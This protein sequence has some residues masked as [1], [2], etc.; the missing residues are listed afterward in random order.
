MAT[1][2]ANVF[3]RET[4]VAASLQG[5][6]QFAAAEDFVVGA[7]IIQLCAAGRLS[8]AVMADLGGRSLLMKP[9]RSWV[10]IVGL[11]CL[12]TAVHAG[13]AEGESGKA[14]TGQLQEVVVTAQF[15]SEKLQETPIA[16][17]AVDAAAM[18]A[19]G[20]TDLADAANH[21]PSVFIA[22]SAYGFGQSA[23]VTIRGI[24]QADPHIALEPGVGVYIDDVYYGMLSGS[25]FELLD[26]DRVE[27]LRGPQG[28]LQG[29]N[30]I[31]GSVK[32][33]STRPGPE[34]N[35]FIEAGYGSFNHFMARAASNITLIPDTLFARVSAGT[36]HED[37][38]LTELDYTC[39]TGKALDL[40]PGLSGSNRHGTS[41]CDIGTEGGKSVVSARASLR[42]IASEQVEDTFIADVTNDNSENPAVKLLSQSPSWAG[43]A[44]FI[45]C[46]TCYTNYETNLGRPFPGSNV[47][48]LPRTSP[49][50]EWGISNTLDVTL[51]ASIRLKSITGYRQEHTVFTQQGEA[52]PADVVDQIWSMQTRQFTE[53][54][55]LLGTIG[56]IVD[57]TV[58]GFFYDARGFSSGR[59][60]IPGGFALGG[61]G[62]GLDF[63]L[64][65]P[66]RTRSTSGFAHFVVHATDR[67]DVTLAGR[68]THDIKN[69]T[70]NR[71][72][73]DG[74]PY[75]LLSSLEDVTGRFSGNR[76]DYRAAIDYRWTDNLLT[77]A[78]VSTGFKG[79]GVNPRPY[80][81]SQVVNFNPETLLTY[82][83]GLKS[84]FL[85]HRARV[86][87]AAYSSKYKDI[88]L[89]L[90]RCDN[91]SPF[92]GAPCAATENVGDANVKGV[93]LETELRPTRRW[94]FDASVGY[95]DF[96]YT[97]T[98]PFSG[99]TIGMQNIYAPKLTASAGTQYTIELPNG[100]SL[101]P[102]VDYSYRSEIWTLPVNDP[103]NRIGG[104]GLANARLTWQDSSQVWEAAL[105]ITNLTNKFYYISENPNLGAPYFANIGTPGR[106]REYFF[107]VK[108]SF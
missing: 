13:A 79:G 23:S 1:V 89:Q 39:A 60:Q 12:G 96:R 99:V 73:L 16:I 19:R 81:A 40:G 11:G 97:R 84:E 95:M 29:K 35:A 105:A 14:D 7:S 18:A 48:S 27:V 51:P 90:L 70:F 33:F 68:F 62:L 9:I 36:I 28:T 32:L 77:Y 41:N 94:S 67:L 24:G 80:F 74:Q 108:R 106:P 58:G 69:F 78:Q 2:P 64:D 85:D 45:T 63:L 98:N 47:F 10:A 3:F 52:S 59:I 71:L 104:R 43:T 34:P 55:R 100:S 6:R 26:A 22:Q 46:S 93:E 83:V 72:G 103:G 50:N 54:I 107:T 65:D 5:K 56:R 25:I 38:Y 87:L 102:R 30:S 92:P 76:F 17:T 4:E 57:W 8:V 42:W 75:P 101:T 49:L 53:E 44:N 20:M 61:G 21:A 31:G 82:E 37:G 88:Q 86:N 91:I 15:R 66:V